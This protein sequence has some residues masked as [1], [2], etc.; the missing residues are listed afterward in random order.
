[1][2][3]EQDKFQPRM[4]VFYSY[5]NH[6]FVFSKTQNKMFFHQNFTVSDDLAPA[7]WPILLSPASTFLV[8]ILDDTPRV[9]AE[10]V[11]KTL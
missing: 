3:T 11:A 6:K 8:H 10:F 9:A 7:W 1:L 2:A 5:T 4:R